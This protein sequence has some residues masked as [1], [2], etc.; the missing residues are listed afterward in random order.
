MN[1]LNVNRPLGGK[2]DLIGS[3]KVFS[4]LVL[5]DKQAHHLTPLNR[6]IKSKREPEKLIIRYLRSQN[7]LIAETVQKS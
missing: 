4:K 1:K 5:P 3:E 2:G 6:L 7:N